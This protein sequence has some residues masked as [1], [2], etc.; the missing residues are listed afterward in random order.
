M[1]IE[2]INGL[3]NG[4]GRRR[5]ISCAPN[6]MAPFAATLAAIAVAL[7]FP[8]VV[9]GTT[10]VRGGTTVCVPSAFVVVRRTGERNDSTDADDGK[11]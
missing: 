6:D 1:D 7:L 2:S 11:P 8:P 3:A 10:G 5:I 9:D 4:D